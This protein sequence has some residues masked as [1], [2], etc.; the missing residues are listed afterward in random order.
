MYKN[1]IENYE[2]PAILIPID[3]YYVPRGIYVFQLY[4]EIFIGAVGMFL[5]NFALIRGPMMVGMTV[6][7]PTFFMP[8][9]RA[10]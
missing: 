10:L 7:V 4:I 5:G 2:N 3:K 9:F 6:N 1:D 8:E